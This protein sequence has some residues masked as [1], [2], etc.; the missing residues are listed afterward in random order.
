MTKNVFIASAEPYSGKSLVALGLVNL[1]LGKAQKVAYF[2]PIINA[3]SRE[4]KD[5]HVETVLSYFKFPTRYDDS[6]AYTGQEALRLLERQGQDEMIDTII[7]KLKKLEENHDFTII[8]GSDFVGEGTAFE[9]DTNINIA[10]N[11]GSPVIIVVSGEGKDIAQLTN[12]VLTVWCNFELR[13]VQTIAV[14]VNKVKPDQVETVKE[15]LAAQ[16]NEDITLSVIPEDKSLLAPTM[17]EIYE[18]LGA[19][20][21]CGEDQLSNQVN[22]FIT[23]AISFGFPV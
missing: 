11:L 3:T 22:H 6:Y 21:V 14:I 8:D 1:L 10:K 16:L 4:K 15:F 5:V 20:I 18:Q 12:S 7:H 13:E 19:E 2:K 17:K 9:F 23:G